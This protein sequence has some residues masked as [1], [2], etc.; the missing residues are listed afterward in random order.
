MH[1]PNIDMYIHVD[2][3]VITSVYRL[4][5]QNNVKNRAVGQRT[6]SPRDVW[7]MNLK[8]LSMFAYSSA[9][10]LVRNI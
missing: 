4:S 8:S 10:V 9:A 6:Q 5:R 2:V 7:P 1:A 3:A